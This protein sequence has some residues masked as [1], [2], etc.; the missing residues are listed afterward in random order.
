[1]IFPHTASD[2]ITARHAQQ[3]Q[4]AIYWP[5]PIAD[6]MIWLFIQ[7]FVSFR[8]TAIDMP[9]LAGRQAVSRL[10]RRDD[11][12][13]RR[14]LFSPRYYD[15]PR[16]RSL[17][18]DAKAAELCSFSPSARSHR[19]QWRYRRASSKMA[20]A[21]FSSPSIFTSRLFIGLVLSFAAR[22]A[23]TAALSTARGA[24]AGFLSATMPPSRRRSRDD[25]TLRF[26]LATSFRDAHSASIS[27]VFISDDA[28]YRR[29]RSQRIPA[30]PTASPS[31]TPWRDDDEELISRRRP[32]R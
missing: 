25:T 22:R 26:R 5:R 13:P 19:A 11:P 20:S 6:A 24:Y 30:P 32:R 15:T 9:A 27:G 14:A 17:E 23:A 7:P 31:L 10:H 8:V 16:K 2:D 4:R 18:A 12:S 29:K 1:M 21:H 3:R 28:R